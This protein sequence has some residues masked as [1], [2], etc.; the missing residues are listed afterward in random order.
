MVGRHIAY[1]ELYDLDANVERENVMKKIVLMITC[2]MILLS[3]M[4]QATS[5]ITN[6]SFEDGPGTPSGFTT[7]DGVTTGVINGWTTGG[8]IDYIG[9]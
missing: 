4:A 2:C 6:G 9:G 8:S 7:I 5:L 1:Y 3:G